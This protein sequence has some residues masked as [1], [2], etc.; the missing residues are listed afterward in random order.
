MSL[1]IS[2]IAVK[3]MYSFSLYPDALIG[4]GFKGCTVL[5]I[6]DAETARLFEDID[7]L[8]AKVYPYLPAGTPNDASA[9]NYLKLKTSAGLTTVIGLSWINESTI[10]AV[11]SIQATVTF[12]NLLST[13]IQKLRD[14][15]SHNG[16]SDFTI[17]TGAN[18]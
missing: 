7:A 9:Y 18:S 13:D 11:E 14:A 8:H 5:S 2:D 4:D 3:G 16:F 10:V 1:T 17:S 6:M 12:K 15:L